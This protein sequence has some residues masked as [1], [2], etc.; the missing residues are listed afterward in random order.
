MQGPYSSVA[1]RQSCKLKVLGSIPSGGYALQ[2]TARRLA[3]WQF[4]GVMRG[5]PAV[6][7]FAARASRLLRTAR[8]ARLLR[9]SNRLASERSPRRWHRLRRAR[10]SGLGQCHDVTR[11]M[12]L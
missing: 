8:R 3:P 2:S 7:A 4:E 12:A 11:L 10:V 9:L 6:V 1:E 5:P